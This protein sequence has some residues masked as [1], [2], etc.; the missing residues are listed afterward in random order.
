MGK[1]LGKRVIIHINNIQTT[2]LYIQTTKQ[3]M[4]DE[5]LDDNVRHPPGPNMDLETRIYVHN[6]AK[7]IHVLLTADDLY[8]KTVMQMRKARYLHKRCGVKGDDLLYE[9]PEVPWP[10]FFDLAEKICNDSLVIG[11][12]PLVEFYNE[13]KENMGG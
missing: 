7:E 5:Y 4:T 6:R 10:L 12:P 13:F 9:A 2:R 11:S 8:R 3:K 1:A